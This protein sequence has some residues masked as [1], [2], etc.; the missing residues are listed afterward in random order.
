MMNNLTNHKEESK[1]S[2]LNSNTTTNTTQQEEANI[3]N[4]FNDIA[5]EEE[6]KSPRDWTLEDCKKNLKV[7]F[8]ESKHANK[9]DVSVRLQGLTM[10]KIHNS[11]TTLTIESGT[12]TIDEVRERVL[13]ADEMILE[14]KSRLVASLK[15]AQTSRETTYK[16]KPK[17]DK[18]H[19]DTT[20][21]ID[22]E[23]GGQDYSQPPY[24][25]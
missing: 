20:G 23:E 10:L 3:M 8:K 14:A 18:A 22:I 5:F 7:I 12:M 6:T 1:M 21:R 11:K 13:T 16:R 25:E 24:S 17:G 19:R 2:N 4:L 15:K 9:I